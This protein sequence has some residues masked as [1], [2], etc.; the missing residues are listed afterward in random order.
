M[1][2]ILKGSLYTFIAAVVWGGT[3]IIEKAAMSYVNPVVL[4]A[5]RYFLSGIMVFAFLRARHAD[6][7]VSRLMGKRLFLASFIGAA[8][9]PALFYTGLFLT[10]PITA[11]SISTTGIVWV[12][13]FGLVFLKEKIKGDELAGT[14]LIIAGIF[15][16]LSRIG[17]D[18][19]LGA[20][21]LITASMLGAAA[22]VMEKKSLHTINPWVVALYDR[23]VGGSVSLI[24]SLFLIG[25]GAIFLSTQAW[26]YL[27][28]LALFGSLIPALL[29]FQGLKLIETERSAAI[30]STAPLFTVLFTSLFTN[31][32]VTQNQFIGTVMIAGGVLVLSASRRLMITVRHYISVVIDHEIDGLR[33]IKNIFYEIKGRG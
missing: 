4:G 16:I 13:L 3:P 22:A 21:M 26:F 10:D 7:D 31:S 2:R 15:T 6:I 27:L 1:D 33:K 32:P 11:A 9:S 30:I 20:A 5:W 18:A 28:F 23:L 14:V 17:F 25:A 24:A 19:S 12:A 8:L 29:F